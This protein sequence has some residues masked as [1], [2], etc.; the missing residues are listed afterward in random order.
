MY[1]KK[2]TFTFLQIAYIYKLISVRLIGKQSKNPKKA[3]CC[4]Q[5]LFKHIYFYEL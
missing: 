4:I 5:L 1:A 3:N 2:T